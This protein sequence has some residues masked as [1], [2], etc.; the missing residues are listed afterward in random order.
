VPWIFSRTSTIGIAFGSGVIPHIHKTL[1][2]KKTAI[3]KPAA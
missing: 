2:A 1:L 3:A